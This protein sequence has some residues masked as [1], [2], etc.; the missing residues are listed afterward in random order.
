MSREPK[1]LT[2]EEALPL[3]RDALTQRG[4]ED[5]KLSV[6]PDGDWLLEYNEPEEMPDHFREMHERG[7]IRAVLTGRKLSSSKWEVIAGH[8]LGV[9]VVARDEV[10]GLVGEL[11][12]RVSDERIGRRR[13]E[14][15]RDR[16]RAE[17]QTFFGSQ[18]ADVARMVEEQVAEIIGA[19]EVDGWARD[20]ATEL[21]AALAEL[22]EHLDTYHDAAEKKAWMRALLDYHLPEAR[23][24]LA[25]SEGRGE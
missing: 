10:S 23:A 22:V 19:A 11:E 16:L 7:I 4:C 3:M 9:P 14:H 20:D 8:V 18:E 12:R 6:T 15:E 2:L 13:A 24:A 17:L 5:V 1:T 25:A 21:R